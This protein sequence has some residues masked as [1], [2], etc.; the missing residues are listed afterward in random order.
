MILLYVSANSYIIDSYSDFAASA[1]AAKTLLRSEIGA[2]VPLFVV[3]MF[4]NMGFQYAG[5]LLSLIAFAISPIPFIFYMYG[6]KIR[7]RSARATQ[8]KR[9]SGP[10][11]FSEK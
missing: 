5:L 2:M 10:A 6:E 7:S 4:H 1:M 3:Q 11:S 9:L 8:S